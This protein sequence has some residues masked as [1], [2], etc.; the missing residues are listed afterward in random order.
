[1]KAHVTLRGVLLPYGGEL[2]VSCVKPNQYYPCHAF[3]HCLL[4]TAAAILWLWQPDLQYATWGRALPWRHGISL[5]NAA[6]S[7][8]CTLTPTSPLCQSCLWYMH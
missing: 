8:T 7:T 1:M 2:S 6:K 5:T 3:R 4:N